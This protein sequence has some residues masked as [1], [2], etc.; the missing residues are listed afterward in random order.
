MT[1]LDTNVLVRFFV[2][3]DDLQASRV[4][5]FLRTSREAGEPVFISAV[6]LCETCWVL[7]SAYAKSK[8]EI[9]KAIDTIIDADVFHLED[10]DCVRRAVQLAR[11]GKA[12][13]VDYLIG[14][15]DVARGCRYTVTFD[16]TLR[17]D[18]AFSLL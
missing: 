15:L 7:R 13:F 2:E 8:L 17:S 6:V 4:H 1:G 3:D 11:T 10:P 12:D 16:R 14:E 18:P 5:R 9:L